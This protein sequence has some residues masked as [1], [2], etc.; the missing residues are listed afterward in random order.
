[1]KRP[2]LT[3]L[4]AAMIPA[5]VPV[6][7]VA[8]SD[9]QVHEVTV[10]EWK[11]VFGKIETRD[12]VAARARL[13]GTLGT[14]T[15]TEGDRI[16][17]GQKIGTITDQKL[18]LQ[19]NAVDA[20]LAALAAQ[21]SNAQTELKR[22]EDLVERGVSTAQ[23]LDG[24]RTQV[25]VL[26]N[27]IEATR[28]ERSVI[29]QQAD[30][31]AVLA[32]LSGIVL[33]VPVTAGA[34]VMPGEPVAM[35]GG[36]GF[37]LRLAVPE[38]HA[39]FLKQGADILIGGEGAQQTGTL[40]KV[41]PQIENGRVIA[42]VEVEGLSTDFVN[43][44]VLVRLPVG[45]HSGLMV[46]QAAVQTRMGLDFIAVKSDD[47]HIMQRAVVLGEPQQIEGDAMIEVVSGLN[48]GD[49][50]VLDYHAPDDHAPAHAGAGDTGHE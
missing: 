15:V 13:G 3:A 14:I 2:F 12:M 7:A 23:R 27:Q 47:G 26:T 33:D 19:M 10:T 31:G 48:A 50:V 46:H 37:F 21:L 42:D 5:M 34:V 30:E 43:A 20:Q 9:H 45:E 39:T 18:I 24:L 35:I 41:Y 16:E 4:I 17:E 1:M 11:A 22:G 25:D 38:R 44:R 40:A 49:M 28:A 36:G 6:G 8:E 29:V 32:P